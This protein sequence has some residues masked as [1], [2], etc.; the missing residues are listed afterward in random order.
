LSL[1]CL[2]A[3]QPWTLYGLSTVLTEQSY[4]PASSPVRTGDHIWLTTAWVKPWP[5]SKPQP[6]TPA[7]YL[8]DI[9]LLRTS[10]GVAIAVLVPTTVTDGRSA[11]QVLS[12]PCG[13]WLQ[14]VL[15][16]F[17]PCP[18]GTWADAVASSMTRSRSSWFP[19][20]RLRCVSLPWPKPRPIFTSQC[21]N[22]FCIL[23]PGRNQGTL[24][25][26][27]CANQSAL[28]LSSQC[29]RPFSLL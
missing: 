1:V 3:G 22:L 6:K 17:H 24:C 10:S 26:F 20:S 16:S 27:D 7:V 8:P 12:L 4:Q 18:L 25:N 9:I 23:F 11:L 19:V 28:W 29:C 13:P 5:V 21:H 14:A 15:G 2:A